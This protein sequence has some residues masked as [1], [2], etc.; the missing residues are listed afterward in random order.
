MV[1][2]VLNVAEKPSVARAVSEILSGGTM[3][4]REGRSVYNKIFEFEYTIAGQRCFM[5]VTSVTGHLMELEFEER[6]RKWHSC[7]PA[8]L[9]HAPVRK[10]VP[11]DKLP[12]QRTLQEE[13]RRCSWLI[14]WLDCD[15][16]GEN[17]AYEVVDICN[18]S[19]PN[20]NI[21][22]ARFS[23]LI[24]RDIHD[25]AQNLVRPNSLFADA[26]DV[27]Q[28][29][30]L[31]IGASFTRFQTMLLGD[32]FVFP[33]AENEKKLVLS[34]GPCQFPTLGFVVERYWEIQAHQP[35]DF[36]T[37][38]C[39]YSSDEGNANFSWK[40]GH[41]FDQLAA[42]MIYEMCVDEPLATVYE[43]TGRESRKYPPHPLNTVELQKRASRYFRMSSEQT[44]KVAEELYQS[45]FISYP[46]TETD[47]FS[48][49]FDLQ[50]I[51][52]QQV[53][54]ST[55]GNYAERLLDSATNLWRQPSNGG[56]DDKAHP[57]IHPTKYSNGELN[58][59]NDHLRLYEL[60]TRHFLAC[61]S[62]PAIG[63]GTTAS[64]D[65]AGENFTASGLMITAKNYLEVYRFES[66]GGS[67]IPTFE[68]GQQFVP[69]R[70]TL[71]MGTTMP[72]PLL[73]E[74]DL[75]SLMDQTGIGTD[76]TMHDHIKKLLDRCY[77]VKDANT[78]FSP[79]KLGEALVMGYD[80]M[81][82][83]LWKPYL[84]AM[85]ERDMKAVSDGTKTKA[86]VLESSLREMKACFLDAKSHKAKM[87]EA[88]EFF[89]ERSN[90]PVAEQQFVAEVVRNCSACNNANMVLRKKPDGKFMVGCLNFPQ[91]RNAVW[92]PNA[93][94]EASVSAEICSRC[95]PGT[96]Y[97]INFKFKQGEIPPQYSTEYIGCVGGCDPVLKEL[98]EICG[99]G[100]R[101]QPGGRQAGNRGP[102]NAQ[103]NSR[104]DPRGV[105]H[106]DQ[107]PAPNLSDAV[108]CHCQQ[109][110]SLLTAQTES[111]RGRRFYRCSSNS[112]DFF[113]WEIPTSSHASAVDNFPTNTGR[114][115]QEQ[116]R[117]NMQPRAGRNG[118][119]SR[120]RTRA[121]RRETRA[122]NGG[123]FV[124]ATGEA[125]SPNSCFVCGETS[126]W[127][128]SCPN[129][130]T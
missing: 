80:I 69:T 88:M 109:V 1:V 105:P 51:A 45:G 34:Y 111:N 7:D 116:R 83:E 4:S 129:R 125:I 37:I 118:Q 124:R 3:R 89:F 82:Y 31:R 107:H 56:H 123:A 87:F 11:S 130:N 91:C 81:G 127:A 33:F 76:A 28:E 92:L 36:W 112:C 47:F 21:W 102:S 25:A 42:V 93:L 23:A 17:I 99:T 64:I 38:N 126:H 60:V 119:A 46:R 35:E 96:V 65:I 66:W 110:C 48:E 94:L 108:M 39:Q 54:H 122:E 71:D 114:A 115:G 95:G 57:P 9:Y 10:H 14:L 13:A 84:R 50:N 15:R 117:I 79:T 75:I 106:P 16:E 43:V 90:R 58:W 86:E 30:D 128:N 27:R 74:A 6:Y 8:E 78:R 40:R 5:S 12:L 70:L 49:N 44:M 85:M 41:L 59:S 63:Y 29:I 24:H 77:A 120:G 26:V 52:R 97:R 113:L 72:P 67:T 32:S 68:V 121:G 100:T 55:W 22:R 19:N 98:I 2:R 103:T 53:Q 61:V 73:S 62:Q 18:S 101:S 104:S 20:L